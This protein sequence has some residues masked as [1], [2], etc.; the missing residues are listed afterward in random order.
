VKKQTAKKIRKRVKKLNKT[1]KKADKLGLS[2]VYE[3]FTNNG[4]TQINKVHI[5]K[6]K[7]Y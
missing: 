5:A 7:W 6:T 2:V 1:L 3:N 4:L